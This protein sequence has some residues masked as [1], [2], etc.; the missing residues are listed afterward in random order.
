M[1]RNF[2]DDD[3]SPELIPSDDQFLQMVAE[4]MTSGIPQKGAKYTLPE[5]MMLWLLRQVYTGGFQVGLMIGEKASLVVGAKVLKDKLDDAYLEGF[6]D[7]KRSE[8]HRQ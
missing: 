3:I 7:A 8:E 1:T 2:K 6:N 4:A 5:S